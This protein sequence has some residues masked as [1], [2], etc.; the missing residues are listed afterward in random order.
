MN[1]TETT[2]LSEYEKLG[3][4]REEIES[5]RIELHDEAAPLKK[6]LSR[7]IMQSKHKHLRKADPQSTAD[8]QAQVSFIDSELR[9]INT[10]QNR[11][12]RRLGELR[13]EY[14]RK[15]KADEPGVTAPNGFKI[16]TKFGIFHQVAR[17]ILPEERYQLI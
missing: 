10:E 7:I 16:L 5:Q 13:R 14:S 3:K 17:E 11:I 6:M 15:K 8:L 12:D 9:L 1:E 4:R 2:T